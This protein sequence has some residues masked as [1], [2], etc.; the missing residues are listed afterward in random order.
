[1]AE[2]DVKQAVD[3]AKRN[4]TKLFFDEGVVNRGLNHMFTTA[5]RDYKAVAVDNSGHVLSVENREPTYG[6]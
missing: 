4:V 3:I 1:V 6:S 5:R 2:L